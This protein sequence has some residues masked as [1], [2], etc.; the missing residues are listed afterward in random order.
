M[1][2]D[3]KTSEGSIVYGVK[4]SSARENHIAEVVS[5]NKIVVS[6]GWNG[7]ESLSDADLFQFVP[8]KN[9]V[10]RLDDHEMEE[11]DRKVMREMQNRT[12]RRNRPTSVVV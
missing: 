12:E 2:Y 9:T 6:N 5:G 11:N 4:L 8:G 7:H 3:L 10:I 1:K